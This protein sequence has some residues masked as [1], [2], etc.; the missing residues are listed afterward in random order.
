MYSLI[1][2]SISLK[3]L[4]QN[5]GFERERNEGTWVILGPA[6]GCSA[7]LAGADKAWMLR[8]QEFKRFLLTHGHSVRVSLQCV[9]GTFNNTALPTGMA[10]RDIL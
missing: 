10:L 5:G 3:E 8:I 9:S 6:A 4:F 7:K 1:S 2:K